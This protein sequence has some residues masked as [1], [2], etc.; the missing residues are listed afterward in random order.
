MVLHPCLR[1]SRGNFTRSFF[2]AKEPS[3]R[4]ENKESCPRG[5]SSAEHIRLYP[6][7]A[8]QYSKAQSIS[9][10]PRME[11]RCV[12]VQLSSSR[13]P[14]CQWP[15][16]ALLWGAFAECK[17]LLSS[18]LSGPSQEDLFYSLPCNKRPWGPGEP[19][20]AGLPQTISRALPVKPRK[21]NTR[22]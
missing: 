17:R 19:L 18:H 8:P 11:A 3:V 9:R 12:R 20:Y 10:A 16:Y 7:E 4:P 5:A 6:W 21:G 2:E 15:P 1:T 14:F 13:V 22:P